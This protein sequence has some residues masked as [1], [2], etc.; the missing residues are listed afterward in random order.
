M[1]APDPDISASAISDPALHQESAE[2]PNEPRQ[3][4]VDQLNRPDISMMKAAN[5][6]V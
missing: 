2:D 6:V 5:A 3:F 1:Q 4:N